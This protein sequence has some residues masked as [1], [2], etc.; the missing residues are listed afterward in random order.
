MREASSVGAAKDRKSATEGRTV[1]STQSTPNSMLAG[2]VHR[3][4]RYCTLHFPTRDPAGRPMQRG[5]DHF[6]PRP[7]PDRAA[8]LSLLTLLSSFL[9]VC[10]AGERR[11]GKAVKAIKAALGPCTDQASQDG[12]RGTVKQRHERMA[13]IHVHEARC[14]W[15]WRSVGS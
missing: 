5:N 4:G 12:V 6:T 7:S 10:K 15:A 1:P 3:L 8:Q 11:S 13:R 14:A 9:L 2:T